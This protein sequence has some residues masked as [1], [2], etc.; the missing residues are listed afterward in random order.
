MRGLGPGRTGPRDYTQCSVPRH[1]KARA[2]T[3]AVSLTD[4]LLR[5]ADRCVKCGLCLPHCPTYGLSR[6]EGESPRG[7][8][9]LIQGLA[10]GALAPGERLRAHLD[11]C[12]GCRACEAVCPSLVGYGRLIDGARALLAEKPGMAERALLAMAEDP[13]RLDRPAALARLAQRSG[14]EALARGTGLLRVAGLGRLAELLPPLAPAPELIP[15]V[16]ALGAERGRVGLFTGCISRIAERE[17]MDA[18]LWLLPRLGYAVRMPAEQVCCGALHQHGGRPEDAAELARR[19]AAAFADQGLEAIVYLSSGCGAQL[20]EYAETQ[21][22]ELPAPA[23]EACAFLE[24]AHWPPELAPAPLPERTRV[25]E[26]CT[27]R[28][29]L[30]GQAAPYRLLARIPELR[31]EP[32]AGNDTCCGAAGTH[33]IRQPRIAEALRQPKLEALQESGARYLATTNVGC[34]LH[35]G[36]GLR[37]AGAEVEIIHPVTLLV[38]QLRVNADE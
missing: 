35:L 29:V 15:E 1:P 33:M 34:A 37:R 16:P 2:P 5:E 32:L 23:V 12:L 17:A 27:L 26:P 22:L 30:R 21:G 31:T 38:R 36:A 18:L 14:L 4:D 3:P 20:S 13:S 28:R 11:S 25:H 24:R 9:A 7:R 19:N 6:D 10:G 8:I